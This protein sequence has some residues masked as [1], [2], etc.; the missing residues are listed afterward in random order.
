MDQSIVVTTEENLINTTYSRTSELIGV[1][2]SL[3]NVA[4]DRARRDEKELVDTREEL[5]HLR[6]LVK[7]YKGATET[8][9]YM[10][11]EFNGVYNKFKKERHLLTENI[12]EF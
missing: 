6:H 4:Q 12:V 10:K 7:Y 2:K 3:S 8:T 1:G 5:E 9:A 11:E